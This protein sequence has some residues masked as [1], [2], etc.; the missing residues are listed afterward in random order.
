MSTNIIT[1]LLSISNKPIRS[2]IHEGKVYYSV[3]DIL[4][5]VLR[6]DQD[7]SNIWSQTKIRDSQVLTI[8]QKLKLRGVDGKTYPTDCATEEG[9]FRILQSVNSEKVEE[10]K[11]WLAKVGKERIEEEINPALAIQRGM[12]SYRKRGM[13]EKWIKTRIETINSRNHLT[14]TLKDHG[15]KGNE[16]ARTTN[17][18]YERTFELNAQDLREAKGLEDKDRL[19]DNMS[20]NELTVVNISENLLEGIIKKNNSQGFK[21]IKEDA[22]AAGDYGAR[23]REIMEE[24][25]GK[26][27]I[28]KKQ[29][30]IEEDK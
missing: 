3:V 24:A 17:I 16:Y 22:K 11:L 8:C 9:I 29:D 10:F 1:K 13:S 20:E 26:S 5:S 4:R 19:R 21:E 12:D 6:D 18:L 23:I 14:D 15:I 30:L 27:I 28:T 7:A 25:L 2:A